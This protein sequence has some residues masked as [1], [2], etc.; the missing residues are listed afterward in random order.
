MMMHRSRLCHFVIDVAGL[1]EGVS[2]WAAALGVT[3]NPSPSKVATFIAV[4]TFQ[5]LISEF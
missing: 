3:E 5:T 4:S 2:F 1:D